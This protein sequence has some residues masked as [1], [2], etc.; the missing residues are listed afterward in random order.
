MEKVCISQLHLPKSIE[1]ILRSHNICDVRALY[2]TPD[3]DL[4]Q[5]LNK[6]QREVLDYAVVVFFVKTREENPELHR[7][8][9]EGCGV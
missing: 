4:T 1:N 2:T 5:I 8:L 6:N 3:V 7:Y 9:H